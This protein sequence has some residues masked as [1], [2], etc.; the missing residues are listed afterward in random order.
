MG[1]L[2]S[3]ITLYVPGTDDHDRV[4]SP[5]Q[6]RAR[7]HVVGAVFSDYFGA[8]TAVNNSEGGWKDP[9]GILITE[10]VT[11]VQSFCTLPA[12]LRHYANVLRFA[13]DLAIEWRQYCVLV[14]TIVSCRRRVFYNAVLRRGK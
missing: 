7:V 4:I 2:N 9:A 8:Y 5:D 13:S 12:F 14:S 1:K 11:L 10:P 3:Q 6:L